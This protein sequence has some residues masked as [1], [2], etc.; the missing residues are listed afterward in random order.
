MHRAR[1]RGIVPGMTK[2]PK[3]PR[4]LNQLAH[5]IV[6]IATG[7]ATETPPATTSKDPA[8]VELGKRGGLKGGR[9]RAAK[10]TP[11]RRAQIARR[12]ATK[13]WSKPET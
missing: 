9:A 2:H 1:G 8:A 11:E 13:R 5:R 4:D 7:D 3:R 10:L 12:A 6:A